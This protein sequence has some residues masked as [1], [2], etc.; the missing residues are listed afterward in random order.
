MLRLLPFTFD[1]LGSDHK[2]GRKRFFSDILLKIR[3]ELSNLRPEHKQIEGEMPE[4]EKMESK[5]RWP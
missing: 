1:E 2:T 4:Q 5:P 3:R